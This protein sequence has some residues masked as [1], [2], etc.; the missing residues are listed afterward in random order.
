MLSLSIILLLICIGLITY[1]FLQL[2]QHYQYFSRLHIPTPPFHF[3]F[4]HL[5]TLWNSTSFPRQFESWTKEYGKIYGVYQGT[6]PTFV[7]SDPDFLQEVFVKQFAAFSGRT[8]FFAS[9][10]IQNVFTSSDATWRR[11]RHVINP[12]FSAAK[13]KLMSPLINGCITNVMEKL[14]DH[15]T[16]D[17]EFNIYTYY[18]RMTMDVICRCAFGLDTDVQ[19]NPNNMYFKKVEELFGARIRSSIFFKLLQVVPQVRTTIVKIFDSI[20][21][22]RAFI[23]IRILPSVSK[24]QLHERPDMWLHNRLHSVIEQRQQTPTSRVDL[25]QLM[26]QVIT[27]EQINDVVQDGSKTNYR[28]TREEIVSNIFI[29]ML[30]G[31]ETTST[32]LAFATYEL[33]RHPEVHR[34]LQAEIDQLPLA[35]DDMSD[36]DMKK[37]PD[38]DIVAQMPYMDLFVSE[39]LRMYPIANQAIQRRASEDTI[40][41]GIKIEKGTLVYADVYSIHYDQELWGPEDPKI[42][43]PERHETKRHPMAY[44]PFGAGPRHCIGMRFAL[45]EMK[46][47]LVR[48]LREYSILPG[49]HLH[50][51][52]N[53][54]EQPALAPEAV[55]VKLVKRSV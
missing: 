45:I 41:Q 26:L 30:A 19:S 25:L 34:K 7:V 29:F 10:K 35:T 4:G 12:T 43:F 6:V 33:A 44:L 36:D 38:Y 37:Y 54:H 50:N 2:R 15:V 46:I 55:W 14:V 39:V 9:A 8:N 21:N 40:V 27:T 18:K 49:E 22:V 42:F 17:S 11:H 52:L 24:K 16:S 51:K 5:K 31:Y 1:Y 23:N 3:F 53:I 13:L 20:N 28:L 48:L 32:T 47:L